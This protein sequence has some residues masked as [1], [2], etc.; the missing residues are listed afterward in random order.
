MDGLVAQSIIVP[1]DC[2]PAWQDGRVIKGAFPCGYEVPPLEPNCF[3]CR[4]RA[5]NPIPS[6]EQGFRHRTRIFEA[7]QSQFLSESWLCCGGLAILQRLLW[8][9]FS[10]RWQTSLARSK[11][12]NLHCPSLP[13]IPHTA[14]R[15]RDCLMRP[16][17]GSPRIYRFPV[18]K[19]FLRCKC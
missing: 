19:R 18:I 9:K 13:R 2:A 14:L 6:G 10:C 11:R 5:Q 17:A 3:C 12:R 8:A 1:S 16:I 7:V 15:N 4:G